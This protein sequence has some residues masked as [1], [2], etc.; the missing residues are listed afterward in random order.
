MKKLVVLLAMVF[1][2]NGY[3]M[4]GAQFKVSENTNDPDFDSE[5][6]CRELVHEVKV[7]GD[8]KAPMLRAL[9]T[10]MAIYDLAYGVDMRHQK[11]ESANPANFMRDVYDYCLKNDDAFLVGSVANFYGS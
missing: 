2:I 10:W 8:Y 5:Y 7:Q 6:T 4:E 3:G 9:R 1:A 11:M